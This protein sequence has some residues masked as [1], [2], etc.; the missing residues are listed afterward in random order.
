MNLFGN[1]KLIEDLKAQIDEHAESI[2]N[3]DKIIAY[4]KNDLQT[5]SDKLSE[6]ERYKDE[7]ENK[8]KSLENELKRV[9]DLAQTNASVQSDLEN[10]KSELMTI[11]TKLDRFRSRN[12]QLEEEVGQVRQNSFKMSDDLSLAQRNLKSSQMAVERLSDENRQYQEKIELAKRRIS[13]M[14]TENTSLESRIGELKQALASLK[15]YES[16]FKL[17]ISQGFGL[18]TQM[19]PELSTKMREVIETRAIDATLQRMNNGHK[20]QT[21]K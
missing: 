7:L 12:A 20:L 11:T 16:A 19:L 17:G 10:T 18:A 6:S 14:N 9:G 15:S 8:V 5:S 21:N 13:Q 2:V 3:K 1:K 4:L